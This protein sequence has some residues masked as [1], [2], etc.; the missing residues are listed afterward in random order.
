M[1]ATTQYPLVSLYDSLVFHKQWIK[2]IF[3]HICCWCETS[4][5]GAWPTMVQ[6]IISLLPQLYIQWAQSQ[7]GS[8]VIVLETSKPVLVMKIH[9]KIQTR[10]KQLIWFF[11]STLHFPWA[12]IIREQNWH[13]GCYH[14]ISPARMDQPWCLV[15]FHKIVTERRFFQNLC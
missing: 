11:S 5:P 4:F 3:L 10:E 6:Q 13:D 14:S 15:Y 7:P 9:W 12:R 2:C 8:T 1:A